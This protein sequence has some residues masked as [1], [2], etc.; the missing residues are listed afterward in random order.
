M[1]NNRKLPMEVSVFLPPPFLGCQD[2]Q[3]NSFAETKEV[4]RI[5]LS[6]S[7]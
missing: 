2:D 5:R 1:I 4:E 7:G 3:A 6:G